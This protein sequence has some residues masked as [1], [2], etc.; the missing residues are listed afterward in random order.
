MIKAG[1]TYRIISDHLGS[2]RL[3]VD[4]VTGAIAQRLDYDSFGNIVNN[5]NPAFQPF[6]F[7]GGIY[8]EHLGITRFGARDYAPNIG[9]CLQRDQI[10]LACGKNTFE[11]V[12]GNP[13]SFIVNNLVDHVTAKRNGLVVHLLL[14]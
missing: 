10:G 6:G 12:S 5:T 7:A 1:T 2:V 8:D 11:S 14:I 9:R 3:V 4:T 13:L